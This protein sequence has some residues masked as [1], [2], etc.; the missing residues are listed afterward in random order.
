MHEALGAHR[1][2]RRLLPAPPLQIVGRAWLRSTVLRD[3][4]ARPDDVT[5]VIGIRNRV[6]H[7]L[8]NALRSI[9]SQTHPADLI[10]IVVVDYGS[11]PVSAR[12][13]EG[14]C[15]EHRA[16]Y[17]R[18]DGVGTWSRSRCLNVGL[19]RADTKLVMTS[20]ADVVL[21]RRYL[22]DAVRVLRTS[23]TSIVCSAMLDL[24]E[25]SVEILERSARVGDD[26]RLE[27]WRQ[28]CRPRK[29]WDAHPSICLAYTA[30]YRAVGGLDEYYEGWGAEDDDMMR[31]FVYLGLRRTTVGAGSFYMHQWH[32]AAERGRDDATTRRNRSYLARS[33]SIVRNDGD[34]GDL[35]RGGRS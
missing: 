27:A 26:L 33:H 28:S 6:D 10:R 4:L 35:S 3:E 16:D 31:R 19:R 1:A 22:S 8:V 20:D 32:A 21:S 30:V 9:R 15:D 17:V 25:E 18:V 2:T 13:A 14:V 7:R 11:E 23:P 12:R 5:V 29:G 24:P 34:W